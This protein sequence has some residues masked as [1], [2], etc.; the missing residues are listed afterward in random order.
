MKYAAAVFA[1]VLATGCASSPQPADAAPGDK[2]TAP[3][4]TFI[5]LVGPADQAFPSGIIQVQFGMR[6][7]NRDDDAITLRSIEL[8]PIGTT[9]PY[10]LNRDTFFF[11]KKI[12]ASQTGDVIWWA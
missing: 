8:S 6:V 5:Q 7:E 10:V 1:T 4:V 9:G 11:G 3:N 2:I 12:A